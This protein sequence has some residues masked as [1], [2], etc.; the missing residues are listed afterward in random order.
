M[1]GTEGDFQFNELGFKKK[2]LVGKIGGVNN[3]R[4]W[5]F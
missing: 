1:H 4:P 2:P 5:L 3:G